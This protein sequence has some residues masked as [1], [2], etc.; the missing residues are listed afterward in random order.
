MTIRTSID[1]QGLTWQDLY[2]FTDL[3]RSAS[4]PG[5]R[6]VDIEMDETTDVAC[7]ERLVAELETPVGPKVHVILEE[8]ARDFRVALD[9]VIVDGGDARE[10]MAILEGLRQALS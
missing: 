1:L 2:D 7:P 8:A 6:N 3:A 5:E 10:F 9:S 4:I